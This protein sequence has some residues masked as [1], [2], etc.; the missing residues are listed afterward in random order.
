M[1]NKTPK[2]VF[3][4]LSTTLFALFLVCCTTVVAMVFVLLSCIPVVATL[5]L[6]L[7]WPKG[8][9]TVPLHGFKIKDMNKR[10]QQYTYDARHLLTD[11]Y[12]KVRQLEATHNLSQ[13]LF[14]LTVF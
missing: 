10:K 9:P 14:F 7:L 12:K 13:S 6:F 4:E 2:S 8:G 5:G 1:C 11:G 3:I